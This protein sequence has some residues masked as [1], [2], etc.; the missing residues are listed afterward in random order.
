MIMQKTKTSITQPVKRKA[1]RPPGLRPNDW[2]SGPD[3]FAHKQ[4]VAWSRH[5]AQALFRKE[6]YDL[7]FDDWMKFWCKNDFW[8]RRGRQMDS[9][10][11]TRYDPDLAWTK[12]NCV[13]VERK[14]LFAYV[15]MM[16]VGR[17]YKVKAAK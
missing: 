12:K 11:L 1:G 2:I 7:S 13:I 4:Y 3:P 16:K 10:V 15:Y 14:E 6:P 9:L 17:P 5:K 8:Q